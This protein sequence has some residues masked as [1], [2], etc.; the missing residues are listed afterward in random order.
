MLSEK[1]NIENVQN[2]G[3]EQLNN[4]FR[5]INNRQQN[6]SRPRGFDIFLAHGMSPHQLRN[7]RFVFHFSFL[8]NSAVNNTNIDWST[9]AIYRREENWLRSRTN[10]NLRSYNSYNRRNVM[11]RNPRNN[12]II[13]YVNNRYRNRR[14]YRRVPEPSINFL[15]GFI[16]GIILNIFSLCILI[17][18]R[19]REK[20]K[21]GLLFGMILSIILFF[22]Q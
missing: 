15:L 8:H 21:I 11:I 19:P 12:N 4:S 6:Y 16:F 22:L 17:L 18:S 7:I 13:L 10:I 1:K 20:F 3:N 5:Q 14:F 9:Q 2:F